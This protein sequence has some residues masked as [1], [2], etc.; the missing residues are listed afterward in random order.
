MPQLTMESSHALGREEAL[1]RLKEKIGRVKDTYQSRVSDLYDEWK[2]DTLSFGFK[3]VG[4]EFAGTVTVE[5]S[6]VK[7]NTNL[8]FAAM[9]FKG[10]IEQKIREELG[11]LLA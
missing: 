3:A 8:P 5:P 4:M 6:A 1:R 11:D 2:D 9:M 10:V 7:L